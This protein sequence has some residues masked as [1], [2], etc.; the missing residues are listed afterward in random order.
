MKGTNVSYGCEIVVASS[1]NNQEAFRTTFTASS[2][3][4]SSPNFPESYPE[5]ISEYYEI[6]APSFTTIKVQFLTFRLCYDWDYLHVC[7]VFICVY[8][9]IAVGLYQL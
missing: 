7:L 8:Y 4:I 1:S 2:G 3:L 5:Y 6:L 9:T